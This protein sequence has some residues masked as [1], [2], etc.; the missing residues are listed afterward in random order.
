MKKIKI[1]LASYN[2]EKY[3]Q[4]QIDSILAQEN[5][6]VDISVAD[7][8][9][10]D[11]TVDI[12]QEKYPQ[13]NLVVN[14]KA[15][16]SAANNFLQMLVD[17]DFDEEFDF[18]AFS[19]QDDIWLPQKLNVAATKIEK[20]DIDL[21]CSNLI[22]WKMIDGSYSLLKKDYPQKKFDYLFEG[23]SAGCTYVFTK[24]FGKKLRD[25]VSVVDRTDW[26]EFSHDW[27]IYFFARNKNYKVYIDGDSHINYRIHNNNVHGHLNQLSFKSIKEKI[28]KVLDGYHKKHVVN[29]I[30]YLEK[31][32]E[33]IK[34]YQDFL[35]NY[36]SRNK[37]I[38]KY[39]VQL[40]RDKK[41]LAIFIILNF[42][43][44]W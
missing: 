33:E 35:G 16:G 41:K 4:E 21:Y 7:D 22:K 36:F 23:G 39:N 38:L 27:L 12:I 19:D 31:D 28:K 2:G 15:T 44:I 32:S 8:R 40:M 14:Q 26:Q 37:M 9:S 24:R 25:F 11:K 5:V 6:L 30:K 17:I 13:V 3:I 20:Q 18:I 34:I 43:K 29:Y 10:R 42:I 1:L